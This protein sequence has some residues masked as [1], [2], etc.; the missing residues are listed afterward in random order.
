MTDSECT[1]SKSEVNVGKENC[2]I[3]NHILLEYY[4]SYAIEDNLYFSPHD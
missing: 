1:H 4:A 3:L 2:R